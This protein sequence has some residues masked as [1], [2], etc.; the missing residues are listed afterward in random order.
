MGILQ[1]CNFWLIIW[2]FLMHSQISISEYSRVLL[3]S[4]QTGMLMILANQKR[5]GIYKMAFLVE[6]RQICLHRNAT[7][8]SM[9]LTSYHETDSPVHWDKWSKQHHV[10]SN[11]CQNGQWHDKMLVYRHFTEGHVSTFGMPPRVHLHVVG[12]SWFMSKT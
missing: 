1:N 6:R 2:G 12:M 9:D 4:R 3:F 11:S 10:D 7:V 5:T 8:P